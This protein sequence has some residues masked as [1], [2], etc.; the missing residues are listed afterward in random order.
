MES[1]RTAVLRE[2][3]DSSAQPIAGAELIRRKAR[4]QR[5]W[6]ASQRRWRALLGQIRRRQFLA[7]ML[8][9]VEL[10]AVQRTQHQP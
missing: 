5:Q 10:V 8:D 6:D 7:L 9:P 4:I 2:P 1:K 3:E